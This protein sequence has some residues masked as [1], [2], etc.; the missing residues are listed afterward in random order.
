MAWRAL[1]VRSMNVDRH[2]SRLKAGTTLD[3]QER[4]RKPGYRVAEPGRAA[5]SA[6]SQ[7]A[8]L[9][10]PVNVI[11]TVQTPLVEYRIGFTQISPAPASRPHPAPSASLPRCRDASAP[12]RN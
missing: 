10:K 7:N 2:G 6:I 1:Q 4:A 8:D 3:M 11:W 12:C 5:Q 9:S